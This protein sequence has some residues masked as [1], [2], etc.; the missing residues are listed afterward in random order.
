MSRLEICKN[1]HSINR[2]H[3]PQ[4]PRLLVSLLSHPHLEKDKKE[5]LGGFRRLD[6][7]HVVKDKHSDFHHGFRYAFDLVFILVDLS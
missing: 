6:S 7:V 4:T 2:G 3:G 5:E 1:L